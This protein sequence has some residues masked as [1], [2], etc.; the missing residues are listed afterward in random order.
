MQL[1]T[2]KVLGLLL[3]TTCFTASHV[4]ARG[5]DLQKQRVHDFVAADGVTSDAE[6]TSGVYVL[7]HDPVSIDLVSPSLEQG[8]SYNDWLGFTKEGESIDSIS[9]G[10]IEEG[11]GFLYA[12]EEET[13]R[14]IRWSTQDS[15]IKKSWEVEIIHGVDHMVVSPFGDVLLINSKEGTGAWVPDGEDQSIGDR[16]ESIDLPDV[17]RNLIDITFL[18]SKSLVLLDE[19]STLSEIQVLNQ[20]RN[21]VLKKQ[22]DSLWSQKL[23]NTQI[24]SIDSSY[25]ILYV[26]TE[27]QIF[28]FSTEDKLLEIVN[29][30]GEFRN[31]KKI[32]ASYDYIYVSD[33][34][35]LHSLPRTVAVEVRLSSTQTENQGVLM[36]L[37]KYLDLHHTLPFE[38]YEIDEE[39]T[40]GNLLLK[41][42]VLI[43][44]LDNPG[45]KKNRL[46]FLLGPTEIEIA[47]LKARWEFESM[48]CDQRNT[49]HCDGSSGLN[50]HRSFLSPGNVVE[51]PN[52]AISKEIRPIPITLSG[53][54]LEEEL[55]FY[56]PKFNST[57]KSFEERL[58]RIYN[59]G[60]KDTPYEEILAMKSGKV[61]VPSETWSFSINVP[62]ADYFTKTSRVRKLLDGDGVDH[63]P[64][65]RFM[66]KLYFAE[67]DTNGV[68]QPDPVDCNAIG[69]RVTDLAN[70]INHPLHNPIF[71]DQFL[72]E[73]RDVEVTVGIVEEPNSI[74]YQHMN[75][76]DPAGNS[77]WMET[78]V[79]REGEHSAPILEQMKVN[80]IE[81][82]EFEELNPESFSL[83]S[84]HGTHV[85]ALISGRKGK[86]WE[87]L[88][89]GSSVVLVDVEA[90]NELED[91][92][93]LLGGLGVK[94]FNFSL[95]LL[96][97]QQGQKVEDYLGSLQDSFYVREDI[98][99]V[100]A[101]GQSDKG[102]GSS[103]SNSLFSPKPFPAQL[104]ASFGNVVTV[105]SEDTSSHYGSA[106]VDLVTVGNDVLSATRRNE[107]D[108]SSGTSHATPIVTAAAAYLNS[109]GY[110]PGNVKARLIAT[111]SLSHSSLGQSFGGKF[112]LGKAVLFQDKF[113]IRTKRLD[114]KGQDEN[115]FLL[116]SDNLRGTSIQ[117]LRD[118]QTLRQLRGTASVLDENIRIGSSKILSIQRNE[119]INENRFK[120]VFLDDSNKLHIV[121]NARLK[122]TL[123][124]S[125]PRVLKLSDGKFIPDHDSVRV[126]RFTTKS[127][128]VNSLDEYFAS[129]KSYTVNWEDK[130]PLFLKSNQ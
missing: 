118:S 41:K 30:E 2:F 98:L 37:Y 83:E 40:F 127:L 106:A 128:K 31:I 72:S 69:N 79:L 22:L 6:E 93:R 46:R 14:L 10:L 129:Q 56:L 34:T 5:L 116:V 124:L 103:Y 25:G 9:P 7:R 58:F 63:A 18:T 126:K 85:A 87:G 50:I 71:E 16:I 13:S 28:S 1:T 73:L 64:K 101:A 23:H 76:F 57:A 60:F 119:S 52:L 38:K 21:L 59:Y 49:S 42:D 82:F 4:A 68:E 113:T 3:L 111:A 35:H 12:W 115:E 24:V 20:N 112:D 84:H 53:K 121:L 70:K 97:K 81:K 104:A 61:V 19:F 78:V 51:L 8:D 125:R 33:G 54:S 114:K 74:D 62:I 94:V 47:K 66:D 86:C 17:F 90:W 100:A 99:V 39:T 80:P 55:N 92:L 75:F 27:N 122:G 88:L 67:S 89:P 36:E 110:S 117:I 44:G 15:T 11:N 26:A 29:R 96:G 32:S 48:L 77:I 120:V 130:T 43:T 65:A 109:Q 91:R 102:T 105:T 45:S 107:L 108:V 95:D 123:R